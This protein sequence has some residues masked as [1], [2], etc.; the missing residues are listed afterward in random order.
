MPND[1]CI[2]T[3]S[4]WEQARQ[5]S[6]LVFTSNR[7]MVAIFLFLPSTSTHFHIPVAKQTSD[8]HHFSVLVDFNG[9][10]VLAALGH[11]RECPWFNFLLWSLAVQCLCSPVLLIMK[12]MHARLGPLLLLT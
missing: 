8:G 3:I 6:Q 5:K 11:N 9:N 7:N 10:A 12:N 4:A 1:F 2:P